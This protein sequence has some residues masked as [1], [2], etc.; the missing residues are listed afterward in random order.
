MWQLLSNDI[1][2]AG[3]TWWGA[4]EVVGALVCQMCFLGWVLA[5]G[6]NLQCA[7]RRMVAFRIVSRVVMAG[8]FGLSTFVGSS[9]CGGVGPSKGP[10]RPFICLFF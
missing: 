7:F 4:M 3:D 5:P 8:Q 1:L 10:T 9:G 6:V 2:L